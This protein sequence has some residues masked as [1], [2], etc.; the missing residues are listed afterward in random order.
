M[1]EALRNL[2][3]GFWL[4]KNASY[5]A[6]VHWRLIF[7]LS[8]RNGARGEAIHTDSVFSEVSLWSGLEVCF[9]EKRSS[10]EGE[11]MPIEAFH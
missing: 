11:S 3:K 8:V 10:L 6:F 1:P 9:P 7:C 4:K 2:E 5:I